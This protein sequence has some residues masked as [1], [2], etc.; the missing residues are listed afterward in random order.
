MAG[1]RTLEVRAQQIAILLIVVGVLAAMISTPRTALAEQ[2]S[3]QCIR[4]G[5]IWFDEYGGCRPKKCQ[6]GYDRDPYHGWCERR[7]MPQGALEACRA[8]FGSLHRLCSSVTRNFPPKWLTHHDGDPQRVGTTQRV[9]HQIG[10]I[11]GVS[12]L[13]SDK[14]A[15]MGFDW[16]PDNRCDGADESNTYWRID[17]DCIRLSIRVEAVVPGYH[18]WRY[19]SGDC[20]NTTPGLALDP[21]CRS[22]RAWWRP[23]AANWNEKAPTLDPGD[24]RIE[25]QSLKAD[26][27]YMVSLPLDI[28]INDWGDASKLKITVSAKDFWGWRSGGDRKSNDTLTFVVK[29]RTGSAPEPDVVKLNVKS[30][31]DR[32]VGRKWVS[33]FRTGRPFVVL[34]DKR[35]VTIGRE[36]LLSNDH[37]PEDIDCSD[38]LEWPVWIPSPGRV[39]TLQWP[40]VRS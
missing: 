36:R 37:C 38:P 35:F 40:S 7:P 31:S 4:E 32:G 22:T 30:I 10:H 16:N 11:T 3:Q 18:N 17:Y 20:G 28:T 13:L 15:D 24:W 12:Y 14:W 29:R 5:F 1:N 6:R 27:R 8:M 21:V 9:S 34:D 19:I 26:S 2:E 25:A 39:S 33:N 23:T